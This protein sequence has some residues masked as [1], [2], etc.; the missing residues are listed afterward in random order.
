VAAPIFDRDGGVRSAI[1]VAV[2]SSR[3]SVARVRKE[4]VPMLLPCARRI[5]RD[6][7]S[8]N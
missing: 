3:W 5:S 6:I 2:P 7:D 4:L 8:R 1:N